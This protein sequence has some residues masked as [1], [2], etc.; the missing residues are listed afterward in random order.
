VRIIKSKEKKIFS[1]LETS[2]YFPTGK[3]TPLV[4]YLLKVFLANFFIFFRS[5]DFGFEKIW[6]HYGRMKG[7]AGSQQNFLRISYENYLDCGGL[8]ENERRTLG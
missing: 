2:S 1:L 4:N 7:K 6:A 5:V 3:G 8:T